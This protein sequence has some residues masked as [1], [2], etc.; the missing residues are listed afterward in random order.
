MNSSRKPH[1]VH[2]QLP[3][4]HE[5]I[6]EEP[7]PQ[8]NAQKSQKDLNQRFRLP[9]PRVQIVDPEEY[10]SNRSSEPFSPQAMNLMKFCRQAQDELAQSKTSFPDTDYSTTELQCKR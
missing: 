10:N 1:Q 7:S 5:T 9:S 8:L 2:H 4:L 6:V 3:P